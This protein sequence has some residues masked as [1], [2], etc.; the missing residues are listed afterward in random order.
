VSS[1]EALGYRRVDRR[2]CL[3]RCMG[4]PFAPDYDVA[5]YSELYFELE[6]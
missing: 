5:T 2:S 1:I 4:V 6:R 3:D